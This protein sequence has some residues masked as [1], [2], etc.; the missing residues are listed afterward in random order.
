MSTSGI[1][2]RRP[3]GT[4]VGGQFAASSHHESG[5]ALFDEDPAR[6][7]P[8]W[9]P[10]RGTDDPKGA[11]SRCKEVSAEYTDF[12]HSHDIDADWVQVCG[13]S[14]EF[15]GAQQQWKTVEQSYWQHYVTRVPGPDGDVYVDWTARQFDPEADHPQITPVQEG[16]WSQTYPIGRDTLNRYLTQERRPKRLPAGY[17]HIDDYF[18]GGVSDYAQTPWV[19]DGIH[20]TL[21]P[22]DW[23]DMPVEYVDVRGAK[24]TQPHL[25]KD[26][27]AHHLDADAEPGGG[28]LP[29]VVI[30]RDE[31]WVI[32]GHHRFV[33]AQVREDYTTEA[34]VV[35]L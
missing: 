31:T 27:V 9:E 1:V 26:R 23:E 15:P 11:F 22:S 35:R 21:A 32:D 5:V 3:R 19:Q 33:A 34:H 8:E 2:A 16:Q 7:L 17:L 13:P 12:L 30:Y 10:P 14:R 28:D 4:P 29:W 6:C 25:A 24:R 18:D 20:V